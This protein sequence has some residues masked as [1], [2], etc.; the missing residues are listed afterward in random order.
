MST[1]RI[2]QVVSLIAAVA[3]TGAVLVWAPV[4][5]GSLEL[6]NGN[7]VP[8]RCFYA[9]KEGLLLAV[10]L[11]MACVAE[12]ATKRTFT[13]VVVALS[14][15]LVLVTFAGPVSGGVCASA[16][17]AC[18]A[19]AWWFRGCGVVSAVAALGAYLV[20]PARKR[21]KSN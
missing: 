6:A 11:A 9:G 7:M 1:S 8:M 10:L 13:A 3:A 19:T 12:L 18:Q 4:C 2:F 5:A 17:M 21:V 14:A 20:D 16:D 15:A